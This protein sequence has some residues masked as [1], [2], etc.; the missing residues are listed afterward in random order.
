MLM[1][2]KDQTELL[3]EYRDCSKIIYRKL[4]AIQLE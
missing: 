1:Y 3:D 2:T 4:E